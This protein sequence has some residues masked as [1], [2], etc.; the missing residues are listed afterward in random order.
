M[1]GQNLVDLFFYQIVPDLDQ[2]FSKNPHHYHYSTPTYHFSLISSLFYV[3]NDE[4]QVHIVHV[5]VILGQ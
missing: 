5:N 1:P 2:C 4:L 3:E